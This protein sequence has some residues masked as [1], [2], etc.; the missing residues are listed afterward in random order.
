MKRFAVLLVCLIGVLGAVGGGGCAVGVHPVP[1]YVSVEGDA[2]WPMYYDGYVVYYD[3]DGRPIYYVD[4]Q[5]HYVPSTYVYYGAL[6]AHYQRYR[7]YY[8]RWYRTRG[9]RYR[10]YRRR[11][12]RRSVH[13]RRGRRSYYRRRVRGHRRVR[14]RGQGGRRRRR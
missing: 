5:A 1:S 3:D 9:Y 4:G 7:P 11:R 6:V 2:Y 14:R 8:R 13:R 10:S 12:Y